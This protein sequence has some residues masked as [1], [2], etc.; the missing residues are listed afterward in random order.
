MD[1]DEFTDCLMTGLK[2]IY[3]KDVEITAEK[4]LKNNGQYYHGLRIN[5]KT[6]GNIIPIVYLDEMYE[7]YSNGS[8]SVEE[9]VKEVCRIREKSEC[10]EDIRNFVSRIVEWEFVKD[11]IYPILLSTEDNQKLLKELVSTSFLDLSIV[12]IIR[13]DKGRS[14]KINRVMLDRY[15]IDKCEL[16]GQAMENMKKD[17]YRFLDMADFL[18]DIISESGMNEGVLSGEEFEH[19]KMYIL[20]NSVK[21]YGAAGIL[22]KILVREFAGSRNFFIL[23]SA[24]HETIFVPDD[25]TFD[26][27]ELNKMVSVTNKTQVAKEERLTDHCY[28]YDVKEDE[29]R[30]CE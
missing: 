8:M 15:G 18:E 10:P 6:S 30:I 24:I 9:C 28:Y 12:Y 22:D 1:Y 29:I 16:H 2:K 4:V 19:G 27:S 14:A 20:T 3:G 25:G 5:M 11:K 7:E 17:G 23:P 21:L 26:S 13:G